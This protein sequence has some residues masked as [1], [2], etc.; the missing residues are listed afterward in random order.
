MAE[1]KSTAAEAATTAAAAE[2][3]TTA[4][5]ATLATLALATRATCNK[6]ERLDIGNT[7]RDRL[8]EEREPNGAAIG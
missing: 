5:L 4:T 8:R 3:A 1:S 2:A 6:V 7:R